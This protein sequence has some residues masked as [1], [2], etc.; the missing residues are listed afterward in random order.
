VINASNLQSGN[1]WRFSKPY[2]ADWNVGMVR[3][4]NVE[5]AIAVAASSAFPP[6]LS[7]LDLRVALDAYVPPSGGDDDPRLT[8]ARFRARVRLSDGGV[9]DNLGLETAYKRCRRLLVSDGGA[10]MA[11]QPGAKKD[12]LRMMLR[13]GG[14]V[15]N[16]VRNLRKRQLIRAF[17]MGLR[18]GAYWSLRS[19]P[20]DFPVPD[21]LLPPPDQVARAR[22][23]PTRLA[24][25]DAVT[26]ESLVNWGYASCDLA[27]RAHVDRSA[28]RPPD[29][30]YPV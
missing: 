2:M 21:P 1:L 23:V 18:V 20:A 22:S 11:P 6:F 17:E 3:E 28:P 16:Q 12:W 27:Y 25:L 26:Q 30:P 19:D 10:K 13:I 5:L 9:Y 7:P 15:D 8:D 4:P 24:A 29:L 14:V